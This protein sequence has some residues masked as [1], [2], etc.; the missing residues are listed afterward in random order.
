MCERHVYEKADVITR[1]EANLNKTLGEIDD[2]GIFERVR[3]VR[4]QKGIAGHVVEQCIFRYPPDTRQEADL[5]IIDNGEEIKTE[6]KTTGM[7]IDRS[8][9]SHFVAKEPLSVT[10]VGV[11]DIDRQEF[12]TSH[13]WGKLARILFVYYHYTATHR[14]V[15]PYD[16]RVFPLKGYEFYRFSD[17]DIETLKN[18]WQI[19]HDLC[20]EVVSRHP[21]N[22]N[23][24]AW[25]REVKADYLES[26]A[27]LRER[28]SFIDLAP[29]FPPRFRLKK[30]LVSTIISGHFGYDL[31][32]LPGR[33]TT[34]LDIDAK[35]HEL[36]IRYGGMTIGELAD[37]FEVPRI[38]RNGNS[39]KGITELITVK[40]FGGTS[41]RLNQIDLFSRFGL[42][43][44]SVTLTATGGRTED[45]KLY[46]VDFD[47]LLQTSFIEEDGSTRDFDFT[48]SEMY[49]YFT[50][51][52]F[53]CILYSEPPRRR[54]E[55][56]FLVDNIFVG[57]K[58]LVFSDEFIDDIVRRLWDDTRTKIMTGTLVD[59][60]SCDRLGNPV[61]NR[62]GSISSAPNFLKSSQNP[63]FMRG[64][65]TDSSPRY[66]TE[67]VNDIH[68]L[69]QYV[70]IKGTSVISELEE[71]ELL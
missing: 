12:E 57:F 28:L 53:L 55:P 16:Y 25:R 65:G 62:S 36:T 66:K 52:E 15:V 64:S 39:D 58:R 70:W 17:D 3:N 14:N 21:G 20:A 32:Q 38:A 56:H 43:A 18:D 34:V 13:F 2:R 37:L 63:V 19:V 27:G 44:K 45:T 4:L 61:I 22:R 54:G 46:H 68:M 24:S 29:A 60:I 59:V 1:L 35:C 41:K 11:Y 67:C 48:D 51:N 5:V 33:Y 42:I 7:K 23:S 8:P 47:E 40:M 69:P 71:V 9:R 30:S 49:A 50:N 26:K 6:L 31:E 10:A